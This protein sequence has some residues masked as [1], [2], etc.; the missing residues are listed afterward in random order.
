MRRSVVDMQRSCGGS[1]V[2][3]LRVRSEYKRMMELAQD[4]ILVG[5]WGF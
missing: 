4:P 5:L 1:G 3:I 2:S